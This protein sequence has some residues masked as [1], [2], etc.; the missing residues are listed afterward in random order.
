LGGKNRQS[1]NTLYIGSKSSTKYFCLYEK[2]KEQANKNKQTD[3]KNRFEIR[4]RSTKAVQAVEE[5]LL[6]QNPRE[7][8]F[9]LITDFVDFTDYPLWEIFISHD[10]LPFEMNPVPVNM[11]RTLQWLEK[12]VIPSIVMIEE[13]D[14]LT[15]SN[16]MKMIDEATSL[17]EKQEMIVEQMCTDIAEVIE[18]EGVFYE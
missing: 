10:N 3:I 7:L 18:S 9:Y 1:A 6:T 4:L 11:E 16:Y 17:T 12:Q 13:I 5:L 2:D 8:V 15:G 14:R